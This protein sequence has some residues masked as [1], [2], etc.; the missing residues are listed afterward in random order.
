[1]VM[2]Q[3][4]G[5]RGGN[6]DKKLEKMSEHLEL[7]DAQ[8]ASIKIIFED[9]M[10]KRKALRAK[11]G[12]RSSKK[13]AMKALMEE[14]NA[15][16]EKVLTKEQLVKFNAFKSERKGK[17]KGRK[18]D[19]RKGKKQDKSKHKE[20]KAVIKEYNKS[21]IMPVLKKQRAKL[22]NDL[23]QTDKNTISELRSSFKS[24]KQAMIAAK[25]SRK[26]K[27]KEDISDEDKAKFKKFKEAQKADMKK[28]KALAEKYQDNITV[29]KDEINPQTMKWKADMKAI[30]EKY[31]VEMPNREEM[32]KRKEAA[33]K[34]GKKR[35]GK[36]KGEKGNRKGG[37]K[38]MGAPAMKAM[39]PVGFLLLDPNADAVN[40]VTE[41]TTT[42]N[43]AMKVFP[44]PAQDYNNIEYQVAN[45]GDITI[46]LHDQEGNVVKTIVNKYHEAGT[47]TERVNL[48]ELKGY[49][50]I[51]VIK[52]ETGNVLTKKFVLRK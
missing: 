5:K 43:L 42:E 37:H 17:M 8:E 7:N 39:S 9:G 33:K 14:Q 6:F 52:D 45:A 2:A 36:R 20:M 34:D 35:K 41:K 13:A 31:D 3:P 30:F 27:S 40:E 16:I 46:E 49:I 15:A 12:D 10:K 38:R 47:Y 51:Y 26:G 48:G 24:R 32:K 11:E 18:G 28:A 22:E 21:N 4:N 50:Y 19:F 29:L 44:N 25:N 1:M 23:S